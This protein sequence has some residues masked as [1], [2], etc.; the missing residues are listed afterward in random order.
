MSNTINIERLYKRYNQFGEYSKD[1][2]IKNP[3]NIII[4]YLESKKMDIDFDKRI[5]ELEINDMKEKMDNTKLLL[6]DRFMEQPKSSFVRII[7][8][9][10]VL[11]SIPK[12]YFIRNEL[13]SYSII[14]ITVAI[15]MYYLGLHTY[16]FA[17]LP[18]EKTELNNI[19]SRTDFYIDLLSIRLI[20]GITVEN[21]FNKYIKV[22]SVDIDKIDRNRF[23]AFFRENGLTFILNVPEFIDYIIYK[24]ETLFLS[25]GNKKEI[26]EYYINKGSL[27]EDL[28]YDT[29]SF[30]FKESYHTLFYYPQ[31]KK[32]EIDILIR[33]E[34]N[35]LALE[36]KSGTFYTYGV[37]SDEELLKKI[38]NKTKKGY[39]ELKNL[40]SFLRN[41]TFYEFTCKNFNISGKYQNHV[42]IHISMYS[43]D[44]IASNLHTDFPEYLDADNPILTLSFEHFL[45][46]LV[47]SKQRGANLW[48]YFNI[49]KEYIKKYP[50]MFFDVNEL[51]LYYELNDSNQN[52]MLKEMMKSGLL[53]QINPNAFVVSTFRDENGKE[54]RPSQNMI[55]SL[56]SSLFCEMCIHGKKNY[57]LNKRYLKNIES[58]LRYKD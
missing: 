20:R 45:A 25:T 39:N 10:V 2:T 16:K 24:T 55:D 28:V 12:N 42:S 52:T 17:N 51:D 53:N 56:E 47:D 36:C 43:M 4:A 33:D 18:I 27:F 23:N 9:K 31:N 46:L 38:S 37:L 32:V 30:F 49:R 11:N 54:F 44:F 21:D 19:I 7:L 6:S 34:V 15:A 29:C 57:G 14:G 8:L 5:M 22:Y 40:N 58:Y 48:D 1:W 13:D 35:T 26:D 3:N 50:N 41:N